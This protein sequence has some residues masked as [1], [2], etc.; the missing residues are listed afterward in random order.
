M[1][2][3]ITAVLVVFSI[4]IAADNALQFDGID[5]HVTVPNSPSLNPTDEIT[6]CAWVKAEEWIIDKTSRVLQKGLT[7]NQY[8]LCHN[9]GNF[10][11]LIAG[12]GSL[13]AQIPPSGEWHHVAAVYSSTGNFVQLFIDGIEAMRYYSENPL[14]PIPASEDPLLIAAKSL[15][16]SE[17]FLHGK[18]DDVSIWSK[19]LTEDEIRN[20]MFGKLTGIESGLS[21]YWDFNEDADTVNDL[22][23]NNNHGTL[24]N[25]ASRIE[26]DVH[27]FQQ[28]ALEFDGIDDYVG[29]ENMLSGLGTGNSPHSIEAWIKV[30][31]LPSYRA[32]ILNLGASTIGSHHWLLDSDG[33]TKFGSWGDASSQANPGLTVGLWKHIA[34]TSDGTELKCYTDGILT[35]NIPA[36]FNFDGISLTLAYSHDTGGESFNGALDEVRIWNY[37][38]SEA[39]VQQR[40]NLNLKGNEEGL[41]GCWK[42]NEGIGLTAKDSSPYKNDG[43]LYNGTLWVDSEIVLSIDDD[44]FILPETVELYQNYPNPFNP[45]TTIKFAIPE[46]G[47]VKLYISN[48]AGQKLGYI[49]DKKLEKGSYSVNF[50]AN[51]L[52]SGTYFYTVESGNSKHTRKMMLVK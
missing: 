20:L 33:T 36:S 14:P 1:K 15:E 44:G 34:I 7:D 32:W 26:S 37:A 39:D 28:K 3:M 23:P 49:V 8:L 24:M 52:N 12:Y 6:I 25:G 47:N 11:F 27:L 31:S 5:D 38:L 43:T 21:A 22:S 16:T 10:E 30:N 40:M 4:L 35:Q 50:S 18:L 2:K 9:H 41:L 29:F 46:T 19:A 13:A 17:A 48:I 42:L 45:S 51:K